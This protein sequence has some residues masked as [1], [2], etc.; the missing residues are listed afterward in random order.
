MAKRRYYDDEM[1]KGKREE[2]FAG[3][4]QGA[5]YEP[6]PILKGAGSEGDYCDTMDKTDQIYRESVDRIKRDEYSPK[7]GR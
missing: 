3:F 1:M 4:P 6:Y 7:R 5:F 2:D